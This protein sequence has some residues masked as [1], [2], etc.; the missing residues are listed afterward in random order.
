MLEGF[1]GETD[2]TLVVG[3][4][5]YPDGSS[6]PQEIGAGGARVTIGGEAPEE[7]EPSTPTPDF[8][9]SGKV[10]FLGFIAFAGVYGTKQGDAR[11]DS[12]FDLT[13][14]DKIDFL[15]F[16]AFAG[17][18]GQSV[19]KRA[20]LTKPALGLGPGPNGEVGLAVFPE[21]GGDAGE[22][23]VVVGVADAVEVAGYGMRVSY[24]ASAL[25][26]SEGEGEV[27]PAD[28]LRPDAAVVGEGELVRL[29]FRLLDE[30]VSGRVEVVEVRVS[31]GLGQNYPNP[32]NPDTAVPFA[33]PEG[34][35]VRVA[36]YNLL[37]QEVVV[38]VRGYREAGYYREVWDGRDARGRV[39]SSGIYLVQM[40]SGRFSDV[41]KMLLVK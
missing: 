27:V 6:V 20:V 31:D 7:P 9:G 29:R 8:D 10:D 41:R 24:G 1:T 26:P 17:K 13:G 14:D 38:L 2:V 36:V 11:Y 33:I 18:Y 23:T 5:G 30:T 15:D 28:A 37:G 22:I 4:F 3:S 12:K 35:E 34:G 21:A 16:I 39:V 32:F 25:V 19:C 40:V